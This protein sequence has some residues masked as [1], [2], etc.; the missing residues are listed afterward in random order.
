MSTAELSSTSSV[1]IRL[2]S[3]P[4]PPV[5]GQVSGRSMTPSRVM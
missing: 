1:W 5:A 4:K 2:P 3:T